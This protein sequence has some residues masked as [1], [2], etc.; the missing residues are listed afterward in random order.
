MRGKDQS[1]Q[2]D[3][4]KLREGENARK[5]RNPTDERF[6]YLRGRNPREHPYLKNAA[7]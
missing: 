6:A 1:K 4:R 2:G 3:A 7:P 5:Q